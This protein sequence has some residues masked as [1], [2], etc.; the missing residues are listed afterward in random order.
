ML[1]TDN[2]GGRLADN[3]AGF[4]RA[5]RHAGL[6][7]DGERVV[8][9]TRALM[10]VGVA[11]RDDVAATLESVLVSRG[12]DRQLFR[13]LFEAFFRGQVVTN[14]P[15]AVLS[16]GAATTRRCQI[17]PLAILRSAVAPACPP[18]PAA[19][20]A[21]AVAITASAL[22]RLR[23][24]DFNTLSA[25]ESRQ[26]QQLAAGIRLQLPDFAARRTRRGPRGARVYWPAVLRE[27]ARHGGELMR[28]P[29]LQRVRQP[30]PLLGLVDV[31]GSMARYG[32]LLLSFLHG[33]TYAL[34]QREVFAFGTQLTDL[35]PAMRLADPNA[36]LL[37][38]TQAIKD[39]AGGTRLGAS[40]GALR[41][42]HARCLVGRRTVVLLI[43]DG[44]DTGD[45]AQLERE[46]DW[47]GRHSARLLWLNPLLRFEAYAPTARGAVALYT[48]C[49]AMLPVHNIDKLEEL[50]SGLATL[51]R[52]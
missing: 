39:F 32:R 14:P 40:L 4:G 18:R 47:I 7:V 5:L 35:G 49:H 34:R 30:L 46:L 9:A 12:A 48:R 16:T 50:A 25:S 21:G 11:A 43:T 20:A 6:P 26:V 45:A 2:P 44:L 1:C 52:R 51:L 29:R 28:L 3:L 23:Q 10:A 31:S 37:A 19:A 27:A 33:A 17:E 13:A 41:R 24:A 36:M 8:L 22:A 42:Q 38:S 15:A